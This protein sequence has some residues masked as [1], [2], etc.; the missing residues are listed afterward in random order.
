VSTALET[1][2]PTRREECSPYL[3]PRGTIFSPNPIDSVSNSVWYNLCA[4]QVT[5][6]RHAGRRECR[7]FPPDTVV[8]LGSRATGV[9]QWP[10]VNL[11]LRRQ[12]SLCAITP[13]FCSP[14]VALLTRLG[15]PRLVT[16]HAHTT[17][18]IGRIIVFTMLFCFDCPPKVRSSNNTTPGG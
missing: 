2:P 1:S 11:P 13:D 7:V 3:V 16:H 18:K 8:V 10:V 4:P 15:V 6:G 12:S 5:A 14:V 9:I 17:L